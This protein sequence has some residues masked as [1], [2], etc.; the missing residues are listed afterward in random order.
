MVRAFFGSDGLNRC[1]YDAGH[2]YICGPDVYADLYRKAPPNAHYAIVECDHPVRLREPMNVWGVMTDPENLV[3][4]STIIQTMPGDIIIA[5]I[6]GSQLEG[7]A[8]DV[9]PQ[10]VTMSFKNYEHAV[11]YLTVSHVHKPALEMRTQQR[12]EE[13]TRRREREYDEA[14][15]V[16]NGKMK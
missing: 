11:A 5:D 14:W 16:A 1:G 2:A 9:R 6:Y 7:G 13:L 3:P 15:R 8:A 12:R 4:Y 10:F